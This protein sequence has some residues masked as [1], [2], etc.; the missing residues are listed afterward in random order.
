MTLPGKLTEK[1]IEAAVNRGDKY[2][3]Y[4]NGQIDVDKLWKEIT[5]EKERAGRNRSRRHRGDSETAISK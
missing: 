3:I 1:H 5:K 2:I 4:R